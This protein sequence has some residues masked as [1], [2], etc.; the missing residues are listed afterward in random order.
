MFP[1]DM[2][3]VHL[4]MGLTHPVFGPANAFWYSTFM[5]YSCYLAWVDLVMNSANSGNKPHNPA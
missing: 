4:W 3:P 1:I 5:T 2:R